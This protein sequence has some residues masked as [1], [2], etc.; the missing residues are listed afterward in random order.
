MLDSSASSVQGSNKDTA[1]ALREGRRARTEEEV[2]Q[3][4]P[5]LLQL[6]VLQ[7]ERCRADLNPEHGRHPGAVDQTRSWA[8]VDSKQDSH[9]GH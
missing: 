4:G 9:V 7:R 3:Q 5:D 1:H 2:V 6:L 8:A